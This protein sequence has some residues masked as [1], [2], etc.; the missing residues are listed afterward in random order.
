[1]SGDVDILEIVVTPPPP[2]ARE[3]SAGSRARMDR[4]KYPICWN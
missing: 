2:H 4:W 3:F 1:V